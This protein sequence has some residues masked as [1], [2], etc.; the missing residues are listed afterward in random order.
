MMTNRTG[1]FSI[2]GALVLGLSLTAPMH[3][4]ESSALHTNRLTFGGAVRLPGVTLT[5][6]TYL[7]ER[8]EPTNPDVIVV[9]S[10]DRTRVYYMAATR[11]ADR[12]AGLD[13]AQMGTL[14]EARR[15]EVPPITAWYPD[16][17]RQGHA[18]VYESR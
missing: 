3:G 8:V 12:P 16:G 14:G 7:F 9:R 13:R 11:R 18:F 15:G 1:T 17:E 10:N 2:L 6:G 4:A 5:A